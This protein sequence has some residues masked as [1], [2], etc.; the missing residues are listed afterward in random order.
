MINMS[1]TPKSEKNSLL[2]ISIVIFL[3]AVFT[4][5]IAF[6]VKSSMPNSSSSVA[7]LTLALSKCRGAGADKCIAKNSVLIGKMQSPATG[8]NAAKLLLES[9]RDLR[10]GC[11]S[12]I[13]EIGKQFYVEFKDEAMVKNNSWCSYGYYHGL[14]QSYGE[15]NLDTLISYARKLC[16]KVEGKL[17]DDCMHGIGHAAYTNLLS[18][19]KS[20]AICSEISEDSFA[21]SCA[22]G[23]IMEEIMKSP[24]GLLTS[25]FSVKDCIYFDNN[26]VISGCAKGMSQQ[27]VNLG[28]DLTQSC[29]HFTDETIYKSCAHGFGMS[30]A[31]NQASGSSFG[32]T[33]NQYQEC[34][35]IETCV[36]GF[37]WISYMYF[38]D[39][40]K[41]SNLCT[42]YFR[43]SYLESC[44]ETVILASRNDKN[45]LSN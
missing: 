1:D 36:D 4:L 40:E 44:I 39:V 3:G 23:T 27:N 38:L 43:K 20:L 12:L 26:A 34:G 2:K 32:T 45:E 29:S 6:L 30:L 7:D 37:G 35:E 42:E 8:L 21:S 14:M 25:G 17:T 5:S 22:D 28:L 11:H 19:P 33:K 24:N 15:D 10:D 18:I 9:R 13:H 31:G 41:A 16:N